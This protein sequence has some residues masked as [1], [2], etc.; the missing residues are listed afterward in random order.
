M[1]Q[2]M[3]N[4]FKWASGYMS[5]VGMRSVFQG[6]IDSNTILMLCLKKVC[7]KSQVKVFAVKT[8]FR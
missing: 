4:R 8:K 2:H 5:F 3:C 7:P 6:V 1:I